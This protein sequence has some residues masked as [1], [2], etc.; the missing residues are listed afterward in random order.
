MNTSPHR[1]AVDWSDDRPEHEFSH[2][3]PLAPGTTI[4]L[5]GVWRPTSEVVD[6]PTTYVVVS[7]ADDVPMTAATARQ[8]AEALLAAADQ[9]VRETRS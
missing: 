3:V 1:I 9:A 8:L 5:I 2:L 4:A 7:G 6:Q